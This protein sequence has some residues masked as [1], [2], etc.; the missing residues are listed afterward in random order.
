MA[1]K[2]F[3][4]TEAS[5]SALKKFRKTYDQ[6][7]KTPLLGFFRNY[8]PSRYPTLSPAPRR[9]EGERGQG[10]N[11]PQ[12]LVPRSS[13]STTYSTPAAASTMAKELRQPRGG[14]GQV[15][16]P[17]PGGAPPASATTSTAE[18][19]PPRGGGQGQ[20]RDPAR[21]RGDPRQPTDNHAR[22][23]DQGGAGASKPPRRILAGAICEPGRTPKKPR[24]SV[25]A[26]GRSGG[27]RGRRSPARSAPMAAAPVSSSTVLPKEKRGR[28]QPPSPR[29][30]M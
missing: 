2:S 19:A 7:R 13:A 11:L 14:G 29:I 5:F 3:C 15:R 26:Q 16:P 10:A 22:D 24:A 25:A 4:Q 23:R 17:R 18:R 30:S 1:K 20:G 8:L 28:Y 27:K 21:R 12:H 6:K 9:G